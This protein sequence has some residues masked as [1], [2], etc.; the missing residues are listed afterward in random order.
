[1]GD[2]AAIEA[3]ISVSV[4]TLQ[5]DYYSDAQIE[6][7]FGPAYGVDRA[8]IGDDTYFVIEAAGETVACGG[9]SKR[10]AFFGGDDAHGS[11]E[12][13]I[14]PR[15]EPARL[16]AF[17]VR[18]DW[19]RRGLARRILRHCEQEIGAAGFTEIELVATLPGE[20]LYASGGYT[21]VERHAV[22]LG[23]GLELPVVKMRRSLAQI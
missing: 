13:L 2:V 15:N 5:R 22:P 16:R 4:R 1:M 9:W 20:P 6:A 7:A 3:L 23:G 18:P 14:D 17:F 19:A 10:R 11:S 12:E 21:V 8:L